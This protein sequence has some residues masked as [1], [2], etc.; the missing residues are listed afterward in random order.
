MFLPNRNYCIGLL[1]AG[2]SYALVTSALAANPPLKGKVLLSRVGSGPILVL[3]ASP[4]VVSLINDATPTAVVNDRL[5]RDGLDA[6]KRELPKLRSSSGTLS[7]YIIYNKVNSAGTNYDAVTLAGTTRY[8][9]IRMPLSGA[10]ANRDHWM[11]LGAH[12]KVPA[13]IRYTV[14]GSLPGR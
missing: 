9:I 2:F 12:A 5:V 11:A 14:V 13:W 6:I 4:E 8:A 3:D 1:L 7:L 10:L